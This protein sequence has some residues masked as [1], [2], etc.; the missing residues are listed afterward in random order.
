MKAFCILC[1]DVDAV[2]CLDLDGSEQFRCQSCEGEFTRDDVDAAIEGA[3]KWVKLL[4]W[5]DA[6]PQEEEEGEAKRQ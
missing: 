4:A 1:R 6:Y 3:K 5:C 2:V